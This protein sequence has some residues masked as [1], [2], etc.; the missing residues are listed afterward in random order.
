MSKW[1]SNTKYNTYVW[2]TYISINT[3]KK[4]NLYTFIKDNMK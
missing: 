2:K 3:V 4:W 1:K